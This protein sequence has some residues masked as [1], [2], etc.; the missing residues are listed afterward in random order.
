MEK[1]IRFL[2]QQWKNRDVDPAKRAD[3][4][5][6]DAALNKELETIWQKAGN[7]KSKSFE[8]DVEANWKKFQAKIQENKDYSSETPIRRRLIPQ[9][10][11]LAA[12]IA[13][14][15]LVGWWILRPSSDTTDF[16]S[17]STNKREIKKVELPDHSVVWLSQNSE[18]SFDSKLNRSKVREVK[19]RG[20]AYFEVQSNPNQPF[21]IETPHGLIEVLGTSFNVRA[22]NTESQTEVQ[23]MSGRVA[24]MGKGK[25]DQRIEIPANFIGY[26]PSIKKQVSKSSSDKKVFSSTQVWRTR[27]IELSGRTLGEAQEI[28][29]RYSDYRLEFSDPQIADCIFTW[30]FDLDRPETSLK[31]LA[32][33]GYFHLEKT[34]ST[35][36]R[37]E[38]KSCP[39]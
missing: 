14:L 3:A 2:A 8:P 22:L 12:S 23:V 33:T 25:N 32:K 28:L 37:L 31:L 13:A 20:E 35:V 16:K 1:K 6:D 11:L 10:W 38:G 27:K 36:F 34:S 17:L 29:R 21:R 5:L 9:S 30:T 7:Y 19:L 26:I 4:G 24:L 15:L 18:L 39:K